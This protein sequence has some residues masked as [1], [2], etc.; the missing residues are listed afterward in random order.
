MKNAKFVAALVT[1]LILAFAVMWIRGLFTAESAAEVVM[2]VSDGF[3]VAGL[4]YL[5]MGALMW[6]STT[7]FFD[8]F[9]YAFKKAA[10]ALIPGMV[11][12]SPNNYYDYKSGKEG[13]RKGF[14]QHS[15]LVVGVGFIVISLIL[16]AVW[17]SISG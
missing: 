4:L 7:G 10:H 13:K 5:C 12:N 8:I 9:G 15:A 17:Y 1:G 14:T 16:T 6:V 3:T 11:D 2:A